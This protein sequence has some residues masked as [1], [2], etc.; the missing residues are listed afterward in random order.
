MNDIKSIVNVGQ[1]Q[2]QTTLNT[3]KSSLK[4]NTTN[5]AN[6]SAQNTIAT[7]SL[8]TSINATQHN[9][10]ERVATPRKGMQYHINSTIK[11]VK[12]SSHFNNSNPIGKSLVSSKSINA[13]T[14]TASVLAAPTNVSVSLNKEVTEEP[15]KQ[16]GENS[17]TTPKTGHTDDHEQSQGGGNNEEEN[18]GESKDESKEENKEE[19]KEESKEESKEENQNQKRNERL[20]RAHPLYRNKKFGNRFGMQVQS[21][22]NEWMDY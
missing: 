17:T 1:K 22:L 3:S 14:T 9:A 8:N 15:S 10:K 7:P 12:N 20:L 16:T 4:F 5:K 19:N 6:V 11:A 13:N 21:T 18:E 2:H